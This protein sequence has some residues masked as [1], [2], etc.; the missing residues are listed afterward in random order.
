MSWVAN[1]SRDLVACGA[2]SKAEVL[3]W[4]RDWPQSE[5]GRRLLEALRWAVPERWRLGQGWVAAG[6]SKL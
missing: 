2:A 1:A 4:E 6:R 3:A 5:Q